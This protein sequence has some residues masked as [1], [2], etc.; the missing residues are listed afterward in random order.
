MAHWQERLEAWRNYADLE[1]SLKEEI[2]NSSEAEL[3]DAFGQELEFGTAGLRGIIGAGTNRM[4]RYIIRQTTEGMARWI[5][6]QGDQA[7]EKGVVISYDNR[8]FSREFALEAAC[9]LGAHG[10][11]S[12]VFSK[13]HPTPL[14]SFAVRY[15]ACEAGIMV[16]A[17]HNPPNYNGYKVY[18][19]D[20]GQFPPQAANELTEIIREIESPFTVEVA[21]Q[22]ELVEAGMLTF[23]GEDV[24]EAYMEELKTV[25]VDPSV[26]EENGDLLNI[27]FSGMHGTSAVVV[28]EVF[29]TAGFSH[30]HLVE[31]Q[32]VLDPD[33]S[34][35]ESPNPETEPAFDLSKVYGEKYDAD[36]LF[37]TDPDA[38]RLGVVVR[39][40]ADDYVMLSGNQVA[41]LMFHYIASRKSEMQT[42]PENSALVRSIVSTPFVDEIAKDFD[43]DVFEVL[44]G[45]KFVGDQI[46]AFERTGS[47]EFLMG[48]EEAIGYLIRP[49]VRDKD[50]LQ[51]ISLV[52]EIATY[53]KA[54]GQ[55]LL[56]ALEELYEK[57]GYY[58]EETISVQ[59][60][61]LSGKEKMAQIMSD[62]RSTNFEAIGGL[63]VE[64]VDDYLK[65]I[66][67]GADGKE[68]PIKQ[69][70]SNVLRYKFADKS[71][72]ALRPSGTEPKIKLYMGGVGQNR[73]EALQK[74]EQMKQDMIQKIK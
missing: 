38:D 52:A 47:H 37:A 68:T 26:A 13:L 55:N 74:I 61:R 4:N 42:L 2:Q 22:D 72:L 45:F 21:D 7:K 65:Q 17:S 69:S 54:K 66:S 35:V 29:K 12:Y 57:Y 71:W 46:K 16:T 39:R 30:Y 3:E 58:M 5:E 67:V 19:S 73:A 14:L 43:V 60:P 25:T 20:G 41:S 44:T 70:K 64:R 50:S 40:G 56:D 24:V 15:L 27:I 11:K 9:V 6:K 34:T 51:A 63:K 10:I 31:E 1:T 28:D 36:I 23:V 8:H 48:F 49:Y 33:F 53:Y 18:G 59:Y 32:M 62:V